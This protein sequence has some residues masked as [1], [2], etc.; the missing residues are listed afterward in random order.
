MII[1]GW[2]CNKPVNLLLD[3]GATIILVSTRWVYMAGLSDKIRPTD[4]IITGLAQKVVPMRGEIYLK[5]TI[6]KQSL[7]NT[8]IVSDDIDCE[9]LIGN[10]FMQKFKFCLDIG[11]KMVIMPGQMIPAKSKPLPIPNKLKV[12]L[13]KNITIPANTA[14][15][16]QGK[17]NIKNTSA[18]YEGVIEP[19]YKLPENSNVVV[20]GTLAYS[21]GNFVPVHCVNF[22]DSEITLYKNQMIGYIEPVSKSNVLSG[23]VMKMTDHNNYY[24][25]SIDIPRLPGACTIEETIEKGKW[26]DMNRLIE[27]LSIDKMTHVPE[28]YRDQLKDLVRE[29]SHC[30][31]RNR[32]DLGCASFYEAQLHL[33]RD[34]EAKWVPSRPV[35][36]KLRPHLD[37]EIKNLEKSGQISPCRYSIWNSCVFMVKKPDN[38]YRFVLDAR[39]LNKELLQD[40]FELPK[41]RNLFDRLTETEILSQLDFVSSFS[42][43][44]LKRENRPLTAFT[45]D[46][47]RYMYNRMVM[48][49]TSS[50]AEFSRCMSLLLN[51]TPFSQWIL[52]VDDLL[53]CS[54]NYS[55]HIKRLRFIFDRLTFGNLKLSTRKTKLMQQEVKFLGCK[56]NRHGLSVDQDKIKAIT[57]LQ[58][59]KNVRQVQKFLGMVNYHR[60]HIAR[61][62]EIAAPLY[63]LTH[64]KAKFVWS[65]ACQN[66]FQQLKQALST[67]PVLGI[68][69]VEDKYNSYEITFDASKRGLAAV[70]SQLCPNSKRRRII[71]YFS[72]KVP[73]HLQKWGATR[74]EFLALHSAILHWKLYLINTKFTCITDCKSLLNWETLF[75]KN[76]DYMQ[77]RVIDLSP[78]RFVLKHSSGASAQIAGPDYIS[79]YSHHSVPEKTVETQTDFSSLGNST[80]KKSRRVHKLS[81]ASDDGHDSENSYNS[82]NYF[83]DIVI[84]D[85]RDSSSSTDQSD[86]DQGPELSELSDTSDQSIPCNTRTQSIAKV[87]RSSEIS[88]NVPVT[89]DTIRDHYKNDKILGEII[90]WVKN[91]NKPKYLNP[92]KCHNELYHYWT[93]FNLLRIK[94]DLLQI[95]R[96]DPNDPLATKYVTVVPYTL[97]ERLLYQYHDTIGNCHSGVDN[98]L[99]Q[100]SKKFYF[101][102]MKKEVKLYVSACLVCQKAKPTN[103]FLKAPLMPQIYSHFGQ[104]IQLD[105]LEPSKKKTPRGNVALL[106][107]VDM[108][109]SY[110]VCIPVR[111][112][113][114]E[115]TVRVLIEHWITKFGYPE[116]ISHDLGSGFESLLFK[117]VAQLFGIKNVKSTPWKS[118]TQGRVESCHRKIN[119]CFR[120]VLSD[121]DFNQYD[122]YIKWIVFTLNC[123]K[124]RRTGFSANFLVFGREIRSPRDLFL[125]DSESRSPCNYKTSAYNLY[126]Q[127][128]SVTRRVQ[129]VTQQQAK[130]MSNMYDKNA[131]GPYF[132]VGE[133]CMLLVTPV[134]HK[135][136]YKWK[137]PY[138]IV[139]KIN[140][141]NYIIVINGTRKIINIQKMKRYPINKYSKVPFDQIS[142]KTNDGPVNQA[143]S[144]KRPKNQISDHKNSSK[145]SNEEEDDSSDSD[146]DDDL[147]DLVLSEIGSRRSSLSSNHYQPSPMSSRRSSLSSIDR[148]KTPASNRSSLSDISYSNINTTPN[149]Q[150]NTQN[151]TISDSSD[152][153]E[154]PRGPQGDDDVTPT[155][156]PQ[157][158]PENNPGRVHDGSSTP[159]R[160]SHSTSDLPHTPSIRVR[161][162]PMIP[163]GR[164]S[165]EQGQNPNVAPQP[166]TSRS[167]TSRQSGKA[168]GGKSKSVATTSGEST[169]PRQSRR[170]GLRPNPKKRQLFGGSVKKIDRHTKI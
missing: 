142:N 103:K 164:T 24:D 43:V 76:N 22:T 155:P 35:G 73:K 160:R 85:N 92:R 65:E 168:K 162:G 28:I 156:V 70:L 151:Q 111:S 80:P 25:S 107:I 48:G 88:A 78:Y 133:Y 82:S 12:R 46:G 150:S 91:K 126:T 53:V 8:F 54:N 77:R 14:V 34:F 93:N 7:S 50:S 106:T 101:Y 32:F 19:Y 56:L 55:D 163:P 61:F 97:I 42:Q 63:E 64:K 9:F 146:N 120:A 157:P 6:G 66:S 72:K 87:L 132:Q 60:N 136:S 36:Y 134:K 71:S 74:L 49:Q 68:A 95:K 102:K 81:F 94:N 16:A 29:Y 26:E 40:N 62:A 58:P 83:A 125:N 59:P 110:I 5:V 121:K 117:E 20:T 79:R 167:S 140:D 166:S 3:W 170:E 105:H 21:R 90:N 98:T 44:G 154:T 96:I 119:M 114:A 116:Q 4:K 47:K 52:Y 109:S 2:C 165:R 104:A 84:S 130:Y 161:T 148:D 131:K 10:D 15:F 144:D 147:I 17:F 75:S 145:S 127:V 100:C 13:H 122:L 118:S 18:D 33:K 141:H 135:Y 89:L 153:F 129:E 112:T 143:G 149:N 169:Q 51:K 152:I 23:S 99:D 123:L 27:E 158:R 37:N 138:V 137:G 108:Y 45:Y 159:R 41:I 115:T 1:A 128:R 86:D 38:S 139:E 30:F 39:S 31:A 69:D 67:S 113:N 57:K 11:N 124:F